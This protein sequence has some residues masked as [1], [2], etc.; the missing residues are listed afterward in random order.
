MEGVEEEAVAFR[1]AGPFAG[2]SR[3][4]HFGSEGPLYEVLAHSGD[5]VRIRV[6]ESGEETDYPATSAESDPVA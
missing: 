4:R 6:V 1:H 5:K 2:L 3:F